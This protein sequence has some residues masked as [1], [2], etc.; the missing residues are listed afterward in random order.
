MGIQLLK[1]RTFYAWDTRES[2]RVVMIN[3]RLARHLWPDADPIG[4]HIVFDDLKMVMSE[5]SFSDEEKQISHRIVGIIQ[6]IK[7]KGPDAEVPMEVYVP[8][9]QAIRKH[10]VTSLALRCRSASA[11]YAEVIKRQ[12]EATCP[13]C[14][15]TD[16]STMRD[17]LSHRTSIRRFVMTLLLTFAS[18]ALSLAVVGIYSV[19]AYT[20]S[21]RMREVGIRMAFGADRIDV[22]N[23]IIKQGMTWVLGGLGLGFV[24]ILALRQV[25]AS[26][27]FG[28]S[29]LDPLTIGVCILLIVMI[30]LAACAIPARRAAKVDPMSVLRYE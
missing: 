13:G 18:I 30:S 25:I 23:L 7:Y 26:Q 19:T 21:A 20:V 29:A 9:A 8:F 27:L 4:Q 12:V 24:L 15:V 1:G 5:G 16:F 3:Q 17:F 6:D 11:A 10:G 22:L 2:D 14:S 28:I